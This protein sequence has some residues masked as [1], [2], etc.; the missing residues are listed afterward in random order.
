MDAKIA[1][2]VVTPRI[3]KPV[4]INALWFNALAS[5]S[6]FAERLDEPAA[7]YRA[8]ADA[9]RAGFQRFVMAGDG[10]LFDVLDGPAGDDA[11]LRPNQILAVSLP[12]SP[13]DEAAQAVVVGCV[14][15]S[16]LT[17][18]GLR[19]LDPRHHDFRPQY[20]GGVWERD[21]SYHQGPV[22][23]WLLGHY[24]LAEYRVHGNAPAAKQ[25]LEAL[26]DHLLD[27]GLGTVS[28]IFDGA[29]PHTPRGAPS[30]AWSVAC[31]LEAW[32]RLARA[33]RS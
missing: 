29:P 23:G 1:D 31:T 33:Q 24:A 2:W 20:R 26:C 8:L 4:E 7:P 30:Q 22:W 16:L 9:A 11:S 6:E 25:R 3:G 5:M 18:Y 12:H 19:S 13:L 10:G 17:S 14:G 28:E 27:A 21:A 32:W 15:R